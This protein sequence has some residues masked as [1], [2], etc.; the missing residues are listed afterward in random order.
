[1][2]HQGLVKLGRLVSFEPFLLSSMLLCLWVE[3]PVTPAV[4]GHF[5]WGCLGCSNMFRGNCSSTVADMMSHCSTD[6]N[7]V[8]LFFSRPNKAVSMCVYTWHA[9]ILESEVCTSASVSSVTVQSAVWQPLSVDSINTN[10]SPPIDLKWT[11]YVEEPFNKSSNV[12]KGTFRQTRVHF[13]LAFLQW[14]SGGWI[15]I[16]E[17][18]GWGNFLTWC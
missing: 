8:A 9:G 6:P 13:E 15:G 11:G 5:V 3:F 10:Y 16:I 14:M 12:K 1:M 4:P 17:I 7:I 2:S 18:S